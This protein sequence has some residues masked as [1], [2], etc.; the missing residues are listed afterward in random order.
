MASD[1]GKKIITENNLIYYFI[2]RTY[3]IYHSIINLFTD[4]T[5]IS[6]D[7]YLVNLFYSHLKICALFNFFQQ[8][9]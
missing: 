4:F 6:I 1:L 3:L 9:D 7:G 5:V 8:Q 2:S